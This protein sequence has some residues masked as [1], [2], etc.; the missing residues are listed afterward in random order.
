MQVTCGSH[1]TLAVAQ[2]D[3]DREELED[4]RKP[5]KEKMKQFIERPT[6]KGSE[7]EPTAPPA[8]SRPAP[9]QHTNLP[10]SRVSSRGE[11]CWV[12][13]CSGMPNSSH[14][15]EAFHASS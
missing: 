4:R 11:P 13:P 1:H 2:H 3:P 12:L 9:H 15:Q 10:I 6:R 8:A 7:T 14:L 5:N